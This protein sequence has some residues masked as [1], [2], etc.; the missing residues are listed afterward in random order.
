M[1][2]LNYVKVGIVMVSLKEGRKREDIQLLLTEFWDE[3]QDCEDSF[4]ETF[5]TNC[6]KDLKTRRLR[7]SRLKHVKN[8]VRSRG[9]LISI[10]VGLL[11]GPLLVVL[12]IWFSLLVE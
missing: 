11:L 2:C 9:F 7:Q 4:A 1:K 5:I 10:A 6:I 8:F 12:V 3:L